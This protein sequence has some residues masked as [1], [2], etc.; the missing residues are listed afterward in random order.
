MAHKI[1]KSYR[2]E[3]AARKRK[4]L[5]TKTLNT[6]G[7]ANFHITSVRGARACSDANYRVRLRRHSK[8]VSRLIAHHD[9][10]LNDVLNLSEYWV[11][12]QLNLNAGIRA[13][14]R[15]V[16]QKDFIRDHNTEVRQYDKD[17]NMGLHRA[18]QWV[19]SGHTQREL[20][21]FRKSV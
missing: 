8:S 20:M 9:A 16:L 13:S 10:S 1:R 21:N 7:L 14:C 6:F 4:K 17:R 18:L 3:Q 19:V 15:N 2:R 5:L 12:K 11:L